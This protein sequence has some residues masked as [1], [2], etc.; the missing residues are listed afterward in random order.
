[1]IAG[2]FPGEP[3]VLEA[4]AARRGAAGGAVGGGVGATG[5]GAGAVAAAEGDDD[6][7][8]M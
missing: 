4:G 5:A 6:E 1:M 3:S 2:A 7:K 8:T